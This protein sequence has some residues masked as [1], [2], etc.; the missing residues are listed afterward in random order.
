MVVKA[1]RGRRR[2]LQLRTEPAASRRKL[3]RLLA[4][5]LAEFRVIRCDGG[6][7]VVRVPHTAVTAA[8][9]ALNGDLGDGIAGETLAT[10][11]TLKGLQRRL[12]ERK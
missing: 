5:R 8:R 9:E 1:K 10:S 6:E 11:G 2:Y 7:A 3:E 12:A 4:G